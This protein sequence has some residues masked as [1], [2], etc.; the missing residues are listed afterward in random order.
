MT[1]PSG[2]ALRLVVL[3]MAAVMQLGG[4]DV[5]QAVQVA[6]LTGTQ[7]KNLTPAN[8]LAA[9]SRSLDQTAGWQVPGIGH[10]QL[11]PSSTPP[12]RTLF[13]GWLPIL[14]TSNRFFVPVVLYRESPRGPYSVAVLLPSDFSLAALVP[15]LRGTPLTDI[16]FERAVMFL[17]PPGLMRPLGTGR[18]TLLPQEV[19]QTLRNDYGIPLVKNS[20]PLAGDSN[21]IS[22][23][24][25]SGEVGRLLNTYSVP[26]IRPPLAGKFDPGVLAAHLGTA[27]LTAS[28]MQMLDLSI[29]LVNPQSSGMP[30]FLA[31]DNAR[32][33]IKGDKGTIIA[34]IAADASVN[35][36]PGQP[37]LFPDTQLT[38]DLSSGKLTLSGGPIKPP[39][40]IFT[41]PAHFASLDSLSF[42]G[43]IEGSTKVFT[44]SGTGSV[45]NKP[46]PFTVTLSE[47]SGGHANYAFSLSGTQ[48]L[49]DL[50]GWQ[51]PGLE[52]IR[53]SNITLGGGGPG[54]TDSAGNPGY[55]G[56]TF[57]FNIPKLGNIPA[58]LFAFKPSSPGVPSGGSGAPS[59]GG[60]G[61]SSLAAITLPSLSS[62]HLPDVIPR[63]GGSPLD[64]L[65]IGNPGFILAPSGYSFSALRLPGPA[66]TQTGSRSRQTDAKGGLNLRGAVD[67][68][69]AG[70]LH[71]L[72]VGAK[73][74]NLVSRGLPLMGSIDPRL[75][76]GGAI[77]AGIA[78]AILASI[79]LSIPLGNVKPAWM[80]GYLAFDN[81][82]ISLKNVKGE[83][84]AAIAA[85]V[86]VDVGAGRPLQFPD[87]QL[88]RDLS[89][90]KLTLSGGPIKLPNGILALPA[91]IASLDTLS[92]V[93]T[94]EGNTRVFTLTGSAQIEGKPETVTVTLSGTGAHADYA[95]SFG[96][97]QSLADLLGWKIPGLEDIKVSDIS[98]GSGDRATGAPSYTGGTI[99]IGGIPASLFV[100][101]PGS[102]GKPAAG[103]GT[104]SGGGG[105]SSPLAAITLPDLHLSDLIPQLK[106]SPFDG[107]QIRKPGFILAPSGFTFNALKLPGPV[108]AHTGSASTDVKGGLNLKGLAMPSGAVADLIKAGGLDRFLS[109]GL[110]LSGGIDPRLL[111]AGS[112]AGD[113]ASAIIASIDFSAP[114]GA[115]SLPGVSSLLSASSSTL[116]IKGH[117]DGITLGLSAPLTLTAGR[118]RYAFDSTITVDRKDGATETT[119]SGSY[120]AASGKTRGASTAI[121]RAFGISWLRI[122]DARLSVTLGKKKS[123]SVSGTTSMGKISP[124][125]AAVFIDAEGSQVTDF[126][127]S[128]TGHE[129]GLADIPGFA[130]LKQI[131]NIGF[132]DLLIS[133]TEVAGTLKTPN[134]MFNNLRAVIFRNGNQL[135]LAAMREKFTLEDII[136]L[137]GPVK[138]LFS[139]IAFNKGL[140]IVSEGG[141]QGVISSLPQ[142]AAQLMTEV[143]GDANRRLNLGNG[144]NVAIALDP[145]AMKGVEKLG[146]GSGKFVLDGGIEGVFGG[147]PSFMLSAAIPPVNFPRSLSFLN[148]P[149]NLQTAFFIRLTEADASLG[150]SL[151]GDFPMKTRHGT[152][153]FTDAIDLE[154]DAQGGVAIELTGTSDNPWVNPLGIPGMTLNPGTSLGAKIAATSEVDLT[155]IGK[156][157]I[158]KKEIDLTG[159]AGILVAEGVVD[160]GAFEGKLSEIGLEDIV[161]LS[162][163][164]TTAAGKKPPATKFPTAKLTNLDVAFAS[165][166]AVVQGMNL[167]G[168]GSRIAGDLW[169]IL[170]DKPLGKLLAQVDGNGMILSGSISDFKLGPV[171]LEGNTLDARATLIPP[172]PPYF[173]VK[174]GAKLFG[175]DQD[176]ELALA[177]N[178]MELAT[179]ID[180]GDLLK[181]DFRAKAD[182]PLK[183]MNP[184]ELEKSDMSLYVLLRS[185]IPAWL[186]GPGRKPVEQTFASVRKGL[187]KFEGDVKVAQ[188]KVDGLEAQIDKARAQVKRDKRSA[189]KNLK[190]AED[191]VNALKKTIDQLNRDI[192][193]ANSHV[194]KCDYKKRVC[195]WRNILKK[196]KCT[197]YAEVA[198]L[199]RD[200]SC[201]A[202]NIRYRAI[203]TAK[204]TELG[205]VVP[206]KA[207]ADGVLE[208]L[209]KGEEIND[210][211]LDPRVA[212]LITARATALAALTVAQDAAKGALKADDAIKSALD[213]FA[214]SDA[215]V[216]KEGLIQGSLQKSIAGKPV[217][218]KLDFV[219][220]GKPYNMDL[221]FSI[222]NPAYNAEQL[223]TLGLFIASKLL[224]EKHAKDPPMAAFLG[225]V[226]NAYVAAH[227][228]EKAK[229]DAAMKDNGLR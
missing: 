188:Q 91:H 199:G 129:I 153:V 75:L 118:N 48:S 220:L 170:K 150:V 54:T 64:G 176:I 97:T 193:N 32:L 47:G 210:V 55:T 223:A 111:N 14:R 149:R 17:T 187:T 2:L 168:G 206:A 7:M 117:S 229:V 157:R 30:K 29:P 113:I 196:N 110:P 225:L 85:D 98:G 50:L 159:S 119:V 78:N 216:L 192:K 106:G 179:D 183:G 146:M 121:D 163:A 128:L 3:T 13:T 23:P 79:D 190:A 27:P 59:G 96:G 197:K 38:R 104:Q 218:L 19:A 11:T 51:I 39:K 132:S 155:I 148:P 211:D 120:P 115:L 141:V 90:G 53:I 224:E 22:W 158:G 123:I 213:E 15:A 4:A 137:P 138:P 185:D 171:K 89:S 56:G 143:Y 10:L 160:K 127:V 65:H 202:D 66:A 9:L 154:L 69:A 172:T 177:L 72:I 133:E 93:G 126:G 207:T 169:L 70:T 5:A 107:L 43:T 166:G 86:S 189:E 221:A 31:F 200:A 82:R 92:F 41:L 8:K 175:K 112:I 35:V 84:V 186:R 42:V 145:S 203:W 95:F 80:G 94:I 71:D 219:A 215:F 226:H 161:A 102:P 140:L 63:L 164:A 21:F 105:S 1:R 33:T 44:L 77:G 40:G 61:S 24:K 136:P 34:A 124:L 122:S 131:P 212:P 52:D 57:Q 162:N 25:I 99:Q 46:E 181:F 139:S 81:A 214:R 191:H 26:D 103:S 209:R 109:S 167:S 37:L 87:I 227:N 100:F 201:A 142:A 88:T 204:N 125:H 108:A 130:A 217:L 174:G 60:S 198:D 152:V 74:S 36:G 6:P 151:S 135:T 67:L 208:G 114:L 156:S 134:K 205:N 16:G 83:I 228:A 222:T 101:K 45:A 144:F 76:G 18:E 62:L 68:P 58:N 73:L 184:A 182:I 194:S 178:E 116:S 147:T 49:A 195:T 165:P 20:I 12:T 180:L 28:F 173:K